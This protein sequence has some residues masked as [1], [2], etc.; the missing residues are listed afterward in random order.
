VNLFNG[1]DGAL[2]VVDLYRGILQHRIYVTSFLRKQIDER[3][4]ANGIGLGRIWRVVPDGAPRANFKLG[5]AA[6]TTAKLVEKLGDANG[7]TRDTAQRL[8]V[9]KRD[10]VATALLTALAVD[11]QRPALARLHAL[12]TLDGLGALDR[13]TVLVALADGDARVCAAAIRLAEKFFKL[14]DGDPQLVARVAA[15]T[16]PEPTVRLQLALTL[17]ESR[18]KAAELALIALV[19][20]AGAQPYLVDAVV[21]GLAR[22]E[23][24]FVEA[25]AREATAGSPALKAAVIAA[26]GAIMK[27]N[28]AQRLERVLTL[29]ANAEAPPW[30]RSAVLDGVEKALPRMSDG[31]VLSANLGAEP[32]ALVDYAAKGG[33]PEA[34][35]ARKLLTSLRWPGKPGMAAIAPVKLSA[36]EQARFDKGKVQYAALCAACHQPE[37]QGLVGL[38]PPLVNSQWAVGDERIVARIVLNGKSNDTLV[39]PTLSATLDDEAIANV[40]TYVR[41]SWGHAAGAVS[42]A[43]VA[44]ARAAT[45]TRLEPWTDAD[46]AALAQELGPVRRRGGQGKRE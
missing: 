9:E 17:G 39:M 42:P 24:D 46:L 5:L 1:P 23:A 22:R 44:Q 34:E 36:E 25:L 8:L 26:T 13:S 21:S 31:R 20:E 45:A 35:R 40:L 32:K 10:P 14:G 11:P 7:W 29:A 33:S 37:G 27:S 41:N 4:L 19:V 12:W 43:V 18:L 28:D 3:G 38:S 2:Y 15:K 16:R 6:A 30:A